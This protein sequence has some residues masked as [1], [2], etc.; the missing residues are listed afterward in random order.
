MFIQIW[1]AEQ[2][3]LY[4][5]AHSP[6]VSKSQGWVRPSAGA[7]SSFC[8]SLVDSRDPSPQGIHWQEA[9]VWAEAGIEP[10]N[11]LMEVGIPSAMLTAPPNTHP[12]TFKD[13]ILGSRSGQGNMCESYGG[14]IGLWCISMGEFIFIRGW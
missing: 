6:N 10:R 12:I 1:K 11:S 2:G 7:W 4:L 8:V 5:L 14:W 9:Q 13:K 3:I